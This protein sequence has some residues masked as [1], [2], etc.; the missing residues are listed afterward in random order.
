MN[1]NFYTKYKYLKMEIKETEL[2]TQT[3]TSEPDDSNELFRKE[4]ILSKYAKIEVQDEC[5]I[6]PNDIQLSMPTNVISGTISPI[7]LD[8]LSGPISIEPSKNY[9]FRKLGNSFSF[10][11]NSKADPILIIGPEW[12][13]FL[14]ILILI[15]FIY[16]F[17]S[18][19]Y[20]NLM[21][22]S[23]KFS[24]IL[25]YLLFFFSFLHTALVNPGYPKHNLDSK[26]GEPRT[27]YELCNF[28][29]MWVSKDKKTKHCN[30]C[31]ICIEGFFKHYKWLGKCIGKNNLNSFY[32][33]LISIILIIG[34]FL[35]VIS[36]TYKQKKN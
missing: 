33:F 23:L 3:E 27:K 7:N 26:T 21:S 20:W 14:V 1:K 36:S 10:L 22:I 13:K 8:E 4:V 35:C 2:V 6:D 11:G 25:L 28:C 17:F 5:N 9:F 18:C 19:Q 15:S 12:K 32:I 34:Y 31:G 29:K 16:L 30:E 24:S